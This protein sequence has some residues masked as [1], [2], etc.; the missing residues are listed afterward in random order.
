MLKIT[1]TKFNPYYK[2]LST[3]NL[4]NG[5]LLVD[6]NE[7]GFLYV[8]PTDVNQTFGAWKN[9]IPTFTYKKVMNV[10]NT[11]KT[12][13][14]AYTQYDSTAIFNSPTLANRFMLGVVSQWQKRI[15]GTGNDYGNAIAVDSSGNVYLNGSQESSTAG[16]ND[17]GVVKLD[18]N[19]NLLWQ[20]RIGG[21]GADYGNAIAVDNSGNVYLNG[22]QESSTAGGSDYG[23][24][25]LSG[26]QTSDMNLSIADM[27]LIIA[28]SN[29]TIAN[30]SGISISDATNFSVAPMN[31]T[32]ADST[33]SGVDSGGGGGGGLQYIGN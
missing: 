8:K 9:N 27:N 7:V 28:N 31:L 1:H 22:Y 10:V 13:S 14:S 6:R 15:G 25:K 26:T 5:S 2:S 12:L 17:Y 21:T 4:E 23:V 19:G 20:K 24:I 33:L 16:A 30:M 32:I 29:F 3:L 11:F 18:P